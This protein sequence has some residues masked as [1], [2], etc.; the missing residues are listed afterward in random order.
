[1]NTNQL[2]AAMLCGVLFGVAAYVLHSW[3]KEKDVPENS[4]PV[5]ETTMKEN[6][7]QE[8]ESDIF[9]ES[10]QEKSENEI[11]DTVALI[12]DGK[13]EYSLFFSCVRGQKC[14]IFIHAT[15]KMRS[16]SMI[17]VFILGYAMEQAR[18]GNLD[19]Y[20]SVIL[21]DVDKVGGAG[22]LAGYRD[23][24]ELSILELLRLMITESDNTAT[25][26]MIDCLGMEK[27]NRYIAAQGYSD[28]ILQRK[29]MDFEAAGKGRENYT[30][31]R[32][33]GDF[34]TKLYYH[35]C[36][37]TEYDNL[38]IEILQEQTDDEALPSALPKAV[39]AH[40][41]GELVGA[42]HDGGIVYGDRDFVFVVLTDDYTNRDEIIKGI[43]K[44]ALYLIQNL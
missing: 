42:Y 41:T 30:S 35:Q 33:L 43:R 38:M 5:M 7:M 40:K 44:M 25:N 8:P 1:M 3:Q 37:S 18:E 11:R 17:K 24:A 20:K 12:F 14:N 9:L 27:I 15:E 16:A 10:V 21:R 4:A 29:M 39:I 19:L 36:V 22:I 31:A 23:G 34:F 2:L 32:D 6:S 26:I 13:A 28:T